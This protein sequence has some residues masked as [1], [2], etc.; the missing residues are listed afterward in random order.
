MEA[1]T[2]F[3]DYNHEATQW[4]EEV[5]MEMDEVPKVIAV[6]MSGLCNVAL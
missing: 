2:F 5:M 3:C 6:F 1:G 4:L